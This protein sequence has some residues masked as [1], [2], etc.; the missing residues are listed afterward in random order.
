MK[1]MLVLFGFLV[2]AGAILAACGTQAPATTTAPTAEPTASQPELMR[3]SYFVIWSR[4]A[5]SKA[6]AGLPRPFARFGFPRT[7]PMSPL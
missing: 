3:E 4:T 5:V 7:T 6:C 2:L 1:K